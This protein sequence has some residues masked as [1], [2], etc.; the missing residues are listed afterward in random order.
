MLVERNSTM[1]Y[2]ALIKELDKQHLTTD[3]K[4]WFSL[5]V[6]TVKDLNKYLNDMTNREIEKGTIYE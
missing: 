5:G 6:F 3:L 2:D 4:H 1:E